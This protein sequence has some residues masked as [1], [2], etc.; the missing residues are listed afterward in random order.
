MEEK[1]LKDGTYLSS[2]CTMLEQVEQQEQAGIEAAA[3]AAY[4]SIQKGGLLHVFSTGH[5]HMIVEE[6]FYRSGG[7]VPVNPIL[8][9]ELMVHKGAITS[10]RMERLHGKAEEVLSA[11]IGRA[12]V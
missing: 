10:T 8:V 11:E 3:K 1:L 7:L 2:I 6:M 4:E 12:H 5:S 9:D